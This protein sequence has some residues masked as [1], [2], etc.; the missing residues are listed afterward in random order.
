MR[1]PRVMLAAAVAVVAA[2]VV[3]LVVVLGGGD[4]DGDG[5][6]AGAANGTATAPPAAPAGPELLPVPAE[7]AHVKLKLERAEGPGYEE[8]L[9]SLPD[10]RMNTPETN[11]NA[12]TAVLTCVDRTGRQTVRGEHPWPLVVEEGYPPHIHQPALAKVLNTVRR[13]RLRGRGIDFAG[14]VKGRLPRLRQ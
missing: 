8:L 12:P 5:T 1:N 13:C 6:V 7:K 10:E 2:L 9:V 11:A 4:S 3:V 14:S